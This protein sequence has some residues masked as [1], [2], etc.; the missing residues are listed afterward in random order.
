M[1]NISKIKVNNEIYDIKDSLSRQQ[2][3]AKVICEWDGVT[4]GLE[5]KTLGYYTYYKVGEGV[6]L[7]EEEYLVAPSVSAYG[8]ANLMESGSDISEVT[9][10][11]MIAPVFDNIN[12]YVDGVSYKNNYAN[13]FKSFEEMASSA[14]IDFSLISEHGDCFGLSFMGILAAMPS[15][16]FL[17]LMPHYI[18]TTKNLVIPAEIM[19]GLYGIEEEV[20]FTPGLWLLKI[21]L[22]EMVGFKTYPV[23][24]EI[25]YIPGE[26]STKLMNLSLKKLPYI[27]FLGFSPSSS[28]YYISVS[29]NNPDY[30]NKYYPTSLNSFNNDSSSPSE[31]HSFQAD[32][33]VYVWAYVKSGYKLSS[34]EIV[35]KDSSL[36]Y[37]ATPISQINSDIYYCTFYMPE[38]DVD[39][40]YNFSAI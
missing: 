36:T 1:P 25:V 37:E 10:A 38:E 15:S 2:G 11:S 34:V 14:G 28:S 19:Q 3:Y 29:G 40:T 13:L 8:A 4:E 32:Q 9:L 17:G 33:I 39:L 21:D 31:Q 6:E 18:N 7:M 22:G 5:M 30:A 24:P 26:D 12:I 20:V 16:G 27:P 23:W 35:G